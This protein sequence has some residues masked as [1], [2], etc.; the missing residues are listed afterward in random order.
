[1]KYLIVIAFTFILLF[2]SCSSQSNMKKEL[3]FIQPGD[4]L[5]YH[6]NLKPHY[7]ALFIISKI[8]YNNKI[9]IGVKADWLSNYDLFQK[10]IITFDFYFENKL[11]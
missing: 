1:M 7:P 9:F 2:N 4:T 11:K 5:Y 10:E 3:S 8:D 6:D